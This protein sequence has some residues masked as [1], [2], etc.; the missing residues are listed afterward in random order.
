[1]FLG[2][3]RQ[4]YWSNQFVMPFSRGSSQ[5]RTPTHISYVSYI[6]RW[7]LYHLHNVGN[8]SYACYCSVAHPWPILCDPMN[9]SMPGF[10]ALQ[11]HPELAQ[12][13]VRWVTDAIQSSH[14]LPSPLPSAFNLSHFRVFSNEL[15]LCIR[16]PK[17]GVS[18]SA[19]VLSTNIQDWYSLGLTGL[20]SLASKGL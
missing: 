5:H 12:T 4:E 16:W 1:M 7:V 13:H 8:P 17:F 18:A 14:P 2:F 9:C 10:P 15:A 11:H 20:I 19:S 6:G 3:S